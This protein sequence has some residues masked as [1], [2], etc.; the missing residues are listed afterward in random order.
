MEKGGRGKSERRNRRRN[1]YTQGWIFSGVSCRVPGD[2]GGR[3]SG[4]E[5]CISKHGRCGE[6]KM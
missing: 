6:L 5:I 4:L 3:R 1:R 2:E